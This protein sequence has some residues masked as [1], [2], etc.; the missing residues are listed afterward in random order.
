ML[1]CSLCVQAQD[2]LTNPEFTPKT[3]L[4]ASYLGSIT[5]PGA[6]IGIELPILVKQMTKRNGSKIVLKERYL[7]ANVGFYHHP[8]FHDNLMLNV[9]WQMRRQGTKRG[10]FGEWA[11][12]IGYSRT[13]LDGTAYEKD[14]SGNIVQNKG[15][16]HSMFMFGVSGGF[17]YDF[18][19]TQNLPM[20]AFF[21]A[22]IT[23][24]TPFNTFLYPRPSV[25]LGLVYVP[26]SFLKMKPK[27][28]LIN[29]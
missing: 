16:G 25:E 27:V 2:Q 18:S 1:L 11:P 17:G 4:K 29:K 21:K 6:K 13:F 24:F 19:K 10:W 5:Y 23:A 7:T 26:H 20:K 12:N 9:E 22:S 3:G 15:A 14:A 8:D 28:V